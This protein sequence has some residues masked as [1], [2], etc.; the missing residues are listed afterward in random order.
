MSF[1]RTLGQRLRCVVGATLPPSTSKISLSE[2][3]FKLFLL[4]G[5]SKVR[6]SCSSESNSGLNL[7]KLLQ[8]ALVQVRMP[9]AS[10]MP[11]IRF[12]LREVRLHSQY[13]VAMSI[14][15]RRQCSFAIGQASHQ[16][17]TSGRSQTVRL[18]QDT[19]TS[20]GT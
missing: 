1:H 12:T 7:W 8:K 17:V 6:G 2:I 16:P 14:Y 18:R 5:P 10:T 3:V 4:I 19:A 11:L 13:S 20:R 15:H 9:E